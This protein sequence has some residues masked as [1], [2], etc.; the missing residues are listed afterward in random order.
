MNELVGEKLRAKKI[1][2]SALRHLK[3]Y[4]YIYTILGAK[5]QAFFG[6]KVTMTVVGRTGVR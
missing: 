6:S 4:I 3:T 2:A 5:S 1:D